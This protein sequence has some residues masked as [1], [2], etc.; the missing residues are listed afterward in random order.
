MVC[1]QSGV[2]K[3]EPPQ[4]RN[5]DRDGIQGV[6]ERFWADPDLWSELTG[7]A[8]YQKKTPAQKKKKEKEVNFY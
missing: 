4:S 8:G 7:T 3:C 6:R 1:G 2:H 5:Q